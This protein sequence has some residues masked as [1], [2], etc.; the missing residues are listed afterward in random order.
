MR[1]HT[2]FILLSILL[3]CV[4]QAKSLAADHKH[5]EAFVGR[6][7]AEIAG[8]GWHVIDRYSDG[9]FIEK[10]CVEARH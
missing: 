5:P 1:Y 4:V 2:R 7:K 3:F 9:D 6:W 10:V 8:I